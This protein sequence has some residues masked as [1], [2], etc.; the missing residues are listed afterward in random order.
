[1]SRQAM[2]VD[3]ACLPVLVA[4]LDRYLEY[5]DDNAGIEIPATQVIDE[6]KQIL[7]D[8]DMARAFATRLMEATDELVEIEEDGCS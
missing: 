8:V 1:M 3:S 2:A 7:D 6:I 4:R 5:L